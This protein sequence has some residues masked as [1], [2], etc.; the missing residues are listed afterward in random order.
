MAPASRWGGVGHVV[1]VEW[2]YGRCP[3][4]SVPGPFV[5]CPGTLRRKP[6]TRLQLPNRSQ[7]E[8][9]FIISSAA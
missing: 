2:S 5:W 6:G 3:R 1:D 8:S 7:R 9:I 4:N